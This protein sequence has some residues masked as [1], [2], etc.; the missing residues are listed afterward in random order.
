MTASTTTPPSE[1]NV[2]KALENPLEPTDTTSTTQAQTS[3]RLLDATRTAT[4]AVTTDKPLADKITD[5]ITNVENNPNVQSG[6]TKEQRTALEIQR[7]IREELA[8]KPAAERAALAQQLTKAL[9]KGWKVNVINDAKGEP[10]FQIGKV[11]GPTGGIREVARVQSKDVAVAGTNETD[12]QKGARLAERLKG[13]SGN[14]KFTEAWMK[15]ITGVANEYPVHQRGPNSPFAQFIKGFND[16]LKDEGVTGFD[17]AVKSDGKGLVL[18]RPD[19]KQPIGVD[20]GTPSDNAT[21][22][23]FVRETQV[24]PA[25]LLKTLNMEGVTPLDIARKFG[26]VLRAEGARNPADPKRRPEEHPEILRSKLQTALAGSGYEAKF[27]QTT[28]MFTLV[29]SD[30]NVV[31]RVDYNNVK[32]E[33]RTPPSPERTAGLLLEPLAAMNDVQRANYLSRASAWFNQPGRTEAEQ[34]AF[35]TALQTGFQ[36]YPEL[37]N[38]KI[39]GQ[40]LALDFSDNQ[41]LRA[42]LEKFKPIDPLDVPTRT[43]IPA[44]PVLPDALKQRV[45]VI[46]GIDD[47]LTQ[48]IKANIPPE[49]I[50]KGLN[51]TLAKLP[52]EKLFLTQDSATGNYVLRTGPTPTDQVIARFDAKNLQPTTDAAQMDRNSAARLLRPLVGLN[53]EQQKAYFAQ[54]VDTLRQAP[55]ETRRR[56][57]SAAVSEYLK[58][59]TTNPELK[60]LSITESNGNMTLAKDGRKLIDVPVKASTP[61]DSPVKPQPVNLEAILGKDQVAKLNTPEL[62]AAALKFF[63][64]AT[65]ANEKLKAAE[66]MANGGIK[67]LTVKDGEKSRTLT[68]QKSGP[69]MH[70][71]ANDNS[72]RNTI[73]L[74]GTKRG[75]D[76]VQQVGKNG[77][78]VGF[79]GD[80]WTKSVGKDSILGSNVATAADRPADAPRSEVN[81]VSDANR[82]LGLTPIV[83][84]DSAAFQTR[85]DQQVR[86]SDPTDLAPKSVVGDFSAY[87]KAS[88]GN[89]PQLDQAK[90]QKLAEAYSAALRAEALFNPPPAPVAG[91]DPAITAKKRA[92]YSAALVKRF[93]D[94]LPP[95]Y[96][97]LL[98][99]APDKTQ[100]GADIVAIQVATQGGFQSIAGEQLDLLGKPTVA[101]VD[102]IRRAKTDGERAQ[103]F[104]DM[105][106]REKLTNPVTS[107]NAA[108]LATRFQNILTAAQITDFK[109]DMTENGISLRKVATNEILS[110]INPANLPTKDAQGVVKENYL[111]LAG[112]LVEPLGAL[113][114]DEVKAYMQRIGASLKDV[115]A[116]QRAQLVE[117]I[118]AEMAKRQ[119]LSGFTLAEKPDGSGLVLTTNR[120]GET[121][122]EATYSA[123]TTG[124]RTAPVAATT[125]GQVDLKAIVGEAKLATLKP[126]QVAALQQL[127]KPGATQPEQL[128]AIETLAKSG[129][130]TL[131]IKDGDKD[132]TLSFA[133]QSA[134]KGKS[135]IGLFAT[136]DKG[137]SRIAIRGMN[138]GQ[139]N[140]VQQGK[141]SFYGTIWSRDIGNKSILTGG[142]AIPGTTQ[143]A[144]DQPVNVPT[145][146][147]GQKI[148]WNKPADNPVVITP[149]VTQPRV[150]Q[151]LTTAAPLNADAVVNSLV[152]AG[153]SGKNDGK[154][155]YQERIRMMLKDFNPE[156]MK[157]VK[158]KFENI[159]GTAFDTALTQKF[160]G[161]DLN[162]LKYLGEG[163][164]DRATRMIRAIQEREEWRIISGR[165][166]E[167]IEKDVRDT[168]ATM[169]AEQIAALEAKFAERVA[170]DPALAQ[171][172]GK[173]LTDIITGNSSFGQST[174]D[175]IA[176][177]KQGSD[178]ISDADRMKLV[179]LALNPKGDA[180]A[181]NL[182]QEATRYMPQDQRDRL[183][184]QMV[185]VAKKAANGN[186]KLQDQLTDYA[187]LGKPSTLTQIKGNLDWYGDNEL[188]IQNAL[189]NM[190]ETERKDLNEG[191]K[192]F[193]SPVANPTAE[194]QRQVELYKQYKAVFERAAKNTFG[195]T[196]NHELV[197][198]MDQ[199]LNGPNGSMVSR[200][201]AKE[202]GPTGAY[203]GWHNRDSNNL[204]DIMDKPWSKE[205]WKMANDTATRGQLKADILKALQANGADQNTIDKIMAQFDK[206]AA[207]ASPEAANLIT[208]SLADSINEKAGFFSSDSAGMMKAIF[209]MTDAQKQRLKDDPAYREQVLKSIRDRTS[210]A[211][212]IIDKVNPVSW[213]TNS[214]GMNLNWENTLG[215]LTMLEAS[216]AERA[217]NRFADNPSAKP[218]LLDKIAYHVTAGTSATEITADIEKFLQDPANKDAV[219]QF[220]ALVGKDAELKALIMSEGDRRFKSLTFGQND[221]S[222]VIQPLLKEGRVDIQARANMANGWFGYEDTKGFV[223]GLARAKKE[224]FDRIRA[225]P[226]ILDFLG[227]QEKQLAMKVTMQ[228]GELRPEDELRIAVLTGNL[229][230][231]EELSN[232]SPAEVM[233]QRQAYETAF[234]RLLTDDLRKMHK[235][236]ADRAA[237]NYDAPKS[238]MQMYDKLRDI[239]TSSADGAGLWM[240][241]KFDSGTEAQMQAQLDIVASR[242]T[243][244]GILKID[245]PPEERRKLM[246]TVMQAVDQYNKSE[247]AA[248][249]VVVQGVTIAAAI[250]IA[251]ASWGSGSAIS[252]SLIAWALGA[253]AA[254]A[255]AQPLLK[256]AILGN[257]YDLNSGEATKDSVLGFI[258]MAAA[259]FT[260]AHLARAMGVSS[261]FSKTGAAVLTN[262][263]K[264]VAT[265]TSTNI[266]TGKAVATLGETAVELSTRASAL[267]VKTSGEAVVGAADDV[268]RTSVQ[269]FVERSGAE[270]LDTA[271]A[272][273]VK[274]LS[275]ESLAKVTQEASGLLIAKANELA[276]LK[277][278]AAEIQ[279]ILAQEATNII[280][281]SM[282][283]VVQEA[284]EAT[285]Q[286]GVM[287]ASEQIFGHALNSGQATS[288]EQ[289]L[290][291]IAKEIPGISAEQ[292]ARM[293]QRL[294][295]EM[296]QLLTAASK[297]EIR[298]TLARITAE[299][300]ANPSKYQ[301]E[302]YKWA[303]QNP[304]KAMIALHTLTG[305]A[306][307]GLDGFARGL[308]EWDPSLSLQDNL[309]RIALSAGMGMGM[310]TLMGGGMSSVMNL[311]KIVRGQ[312]NFIRLAE[313]HIARA[314]DALPT[315][316]SKAVKI[317][318]P[319]TVIEGLKTR[320]LEIRGNGTTGGADIIV[321]SNVVASVDHNGGNPMLR[322]TSGDV[323]TSLDGG[324]TWVKA[325]GDTPLTNGTMIR[326]GQ[327]DNPV[328]FA[329]SGD[330][331]VLTGR[332]T[333]EALGIKFFGTKQPDVVPTLLESPTQIVH[334]GR[335]SFTLGDLGD[336]P[337]GIRDLNASISTEISG[338]RVS[339]VIRNNGTDPLNPMK[340]IVNG[341]EHTLTQGQEIKF[342]G[343]ARI[344]GAD[345]FDVNITAR[346]SGT[347]V[348]RIA[349]DA[350]PTNLAG[351]LADA[352]VI[353]R[354]GEVSA[355]LFKRSL[356]DAAVYSVQALDSLGQMRRAV[357]SVDAVLSVGGVVRGAFSRENWG[358]IARRLS[359]S[360]VVN[361]FKGRPE[362]NLAFRNEKS[363]TAAMVKAGFKETD[364]S[365]AEF[366]ALNK[367]ITAASKEE[368]PKLLADLAQL[369]RTFSK[370]MPDGSNLEV[371]VKGL[372]VTGD[373]VNGPNS[374]VWND[375]GMLIGFKGPNGFQDRVVNGVTS[376]LK[377][378]DKSNV[379]S[380]LLREFADATPGNPIDGFTLFAFGGDARTFHPPLST[381]DKAR[382]AE[383]LAQKAKDGRLPLIESSQLKRLQASEDLWANQIKQVANMEEAL[384]A[385][386]PNGKVF[387]VRNGDVPVDFADSNAMRQLFDSGNFREPF[388]SPSN[389]FRSA[390]KDMFWQ[391]DIGYVFQL[392]ESGVRV[393]Q[394]SNFTNNSA[395][396]RTLTANHAVTKTGAKH[397][398]RENETLDI[399]SIGNEIRSRFLRGRHMS[400]T[401]DANNQ[402]V[403]NGEFLVMRNGVFQKIR[404]TETL[405]QGDVIIVGRDMGNRL[406]K[407]EALI[408][409]K[410][411]GL[412]NIKS[413]LIYTGPGGPRVPL[414][415]YA[416]HLNRTL[417]RAAVQSFKSVLAANY[418]APFKWS[419]RNFQ[420]VS[421]YVKDYKNIQR[422]LNRGEF[423]SIDLKAK[424]KIEIVDGFIKITANPKEKI[425]VRVGD[426]VHT[427]EEEAMRFSAEQIRLGASLR[428]GEGREFKLSVPKSERIFADET[429]WSKMT[430]FRLK[431]HNPDDP[432]IEFAPVR[433]FKQNTENIGDSVQVQLIGHKRVA[434]KNLG[435][436]ENADNI[437]IR[438][439]NSPDAPFQQ[440]A[441][442][443]EYVPDGPVLVRIGDRTYQLEHVGRLGRRIENASLI[444]SMLPTISDK[445]GFRHIN[446]LMSRTVNLADSVV[447]VRLDKFARGSYTFEKRFARN[448]FTRLETSRVP[449]RIDLSDSVHVKLNGDKTATVISGGEPI[450]ALYVTRGSL[451][452]DHA[453]FTRNPLKRN[454]FVKVEN[455][456]LKKDQPFK[457]HEFGDTYTWNGKK[458]VRQQSKPDSLLKAPTESL[459]TIETV[460]P[461]GLGGTIDKVKAYQHAPLELKEG[462]VYTAGRS[463]LADL[464]SGHKSVSNE[465]SHLEFRL[466]V[467]DDGSPITKFEAK[468][469]TTAGNT[470]SY[471][472][473]ADGTF[474]E[475]SVGNNDVRVGGV[476]RIGKHDTFE[477][478]QN[479]DVVSLKPIRLSRETSNYLRFSDHPKVKELIEIPNEVGI[480][481]V[482]RRW[483]EKHA[484]KNGSENTTPFSNMAA[485]ISDDL[486][487]VATADGFT[488]TNLNPNK[489]LFI[490][491]KGSTDF[492]VAPSRAFVNPDDQFAVATSKEQ[493]GGIYT[494]F[495]KPPEVSRTVREIARAVVDYA[496]A[497]GDQGLKFS[498]RMWGTARTRYGEMNFDPRRTSI[499]AKNF[500]MVRGN[501]E[502]LRFKRGNLEIDNSASIRA[503]DAGFEIKPSLSPQNK[504]YLEVNGEFIPITEPIHITPGM[505]IRI[506]DVTSPDNV[507][508][509]NKLPGAWEL[510]S[511]VI[512]RTSGKTVG[513]AALAAAATLN[514]Y[515]TYTLPVYLA[516]KALSY[517]R[518]ARY[519]KWANNFAL[520]A[521]DTIQTFAKGVAHLE[522][523]A[524]IK[525]SEAG[526]TITASGKN[527]VSIR[528]ADGTLQRVDGEAKLNP[529]DSV[530]IG[531]RDY[532]L[533]KMAEVSDT[534]PPPS[535]LRNA[536]SSVRNSVV[537]RFKGM[538]LLDRAKALRLSDRVRATM[539]RFRSADDKFIPAK[540]SSL[541]DVSVF[542]R[543]GKHEV[544]EGK[545]LMFVEESGAFKVATAGEVPD[546]F[547]FKITSENDKLNLLANTEG[548]IVRREVG[549]PKVLTDMKVE[550]GKPFELQ[551]N[552]RLLIKNEAGV[553]VE[554]SVSGRLQAANGVEIPTNALESIRHD[555]GGF[556]GLRVSEFSVPPEGVVIG[557][558]RNSHIVLDGET[559]SKTAATIKHT[560]TQNVYELKAVMA[561]GTNV[562]QPQVFVSRA[563]LA[564]QDMDTI[565]LE[566][567]MKSATRLDTGV[568]N[569]ATNIRSGDLVIFGDSGKAVLVGENGNLYRFNIPAKALRERI[570]PEI[571][572]IQ[573]AITDMLDGKTPF[574]AKDLVR[575]LETH[576][577]DSP[578]AIKLSQFVKD[579]AGT[580]HID[581]LT[582][583]ETALNALKKLDDSAISAE[584]KASFEGALSAINTVR[585]AQTLLKAQEALNLQRA[586]I[587]KTLL[588]VTDPTN[589]NPVSNLL[590]ALKQL[591][592]NPKLLNDD[593]VAQLATALKS[594]RLSQ[595]NLQAV[596]D[597]LQKKELAFAATQ[598]TQFD[599]FLA[600]VTSA[601]ER[602]SQLE[603]PAG[604]PVNS[605]ITNTLTHLESIPPSSA[606][607]FD[608]FA[609]QA[610][611]HITN[612]PKILSETLTINGNTKT[613]AE[614][615]RDL[616]SRI[617]RDVSSPHA[618]KLDDALEQ[619]QNRI[620]AQVSDAE[621]AIE[622]WNA[623]ILIGYKTK[624]YATISNAKS[625]DDVRQIISYINSGN[626]NWVD[627]ALLSNLE[628]RL[629]E[630]L[631]SMSPA[632]TALLRSKIDLMRKSSNHPP[633]SS[634]FAALNRLEQRIAQNVEPENLPV[635]PS[636]PRN[637]QTDPSST[638]EARLRNAEVEQITPAERAVLETQDAFNNRLR[639]TDRT[640]EE[641]G[642][643]IL[644]I[645]ERNDAHLILDNYLESNLLNS[646]M[647]SGRPNQGL[648]ERL[649]LIDNISPQTNVTQR[650]SSFRAAL[651]KQ[652]TNS[653]RFVSSLSTFER[654]VKNVKELLNQIPDS[655]TLSDAI[656]ALRIIG[657]IR[658]VL[659][660]RR[661]LNDQLDILS[662][663]ID[664]RIGRH[665]AEFSEAP[666]LNTNTSS[667]H[668][669][670]DVNVSIYNARVVDLPS[671]VTIVSHYNSSR[672]SLDT[673]ISSR[674]FYSQIFADS[675]PQLTSNEAT[676][677]FSNTIL[678]R[679]DAAPLHSHI[680]RITN[681]IDDERSTLPVPQM[682]S[683]TLTFAA[684]DL[685]SGQGEIVIPI[686]RRGTAYT[687]IEGLTKQQ[688]AD[689]MV[690]GIIAFRNSHPDVKIKIATDGDEE[691][692][693]L[694]SEGLRNYQLKKK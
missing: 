363:M 126:D 437:Y 328:V 210:T 622:F 543:V 12:A 327:A 252:A 449:D 576:Q 223:E 466:G 355:N 180:T 175:A 48:Q 560:D 629:P 40:P 606:A 553:P 421:E 60:G 388:N 103:I 498:Q 643:V 435:V 565:S 519:R 474:K 132:R 140:Y 641:I 179:N 170:S 54:M 135:Y 467:G 524:K 345:G 1:E 538:R 485:N 521:D 368:R 151:P 2:P 113:K 583:L 43:D 31:G 383:L 448:S 527:D 112:R 130:R 397:I 178:K 362:A 566:T 468:A 649:R 554:Y 197:G 260:P 400:V 333:A 199:A 676:G 288:Y 226:A 349:S 243:E 637:P 640:Q 209:E 75:D 169:T 585:E 458:T 234:N 13:F 607:E 366:N 598:R 324:K 271:A 687:R 480:N 110:R 30:G 661:Q 173:S 535:R 218:D 436:G 593:I 212:W 373:S 191:R 133:V 546:N 627:A 118:K 609:A 52:G 420:R 302:M 463:R 570:A 639:T 612:N 628:S 90:A 138:D 657:S 393:T 229:Q 272:Q 655:L 459:P 611:L 646:I 689:D 488:A 99:F 317:E 677:N 370:T 293:A 238:V 62:Q 100:Q 631:S 367:L 287:K 581:D 149:D 86:F 85:M 454:E 325:A 582:K 433:Q 342:I 518:N 285:V 544:S 159:T 131:K 337:T 597:S 283:R 182:F 439:L 442:N 72:G 264:A 600:L 276:A 217:V 482:V 462:K 683:D 352:P 145:I 499:W 343:S 478:V 556:G 426:K 148:D 633:D 398:L 262:E 320:P 44:A 214:L 360:D 308:I 681:Y 512:S 232:K 418:S 313:T 685:P 37:Q 194:Q 579:N 69:Y 479:G 660:N 34:T 47:A 430:S 503:T 632:D 68:F 109:V 299:N 247:H 246:D 509:L 227:P 323:F 662:A 610:I 176:I 476:V 399:G 623:S 190:S 432:Y 240:V 65:P 666:L 522:G 78:P 638:T 24:T 684:R 242:M 105:M 186:E 213:L 134:G 294:T 21:L 319:N 573:T 425:Y 278:P 281:A 528:R 74:R 143:P 95:E 196:N 156:Q 428:I 486:R 338:T 125:D 354:P 434:I 50:L 311:G 659:N 526:F 616:L 645:S 164:D 589:A 371:F 423:D 396:S 490:K 77:R 617:Q 693:K 17:L 195:V 97:Q 266:F 305:T 654:T 230:R 441:R 184:D 248:A 231:L 188:G 174:K 177:L 648:I 124:D 605:T 64:A 525:A 129:L 206:R 464:P 584:A 269:A 431:E 417:S 172:K 237:L 615:L 92:D 26:D 330:S 534:P 545:P 346:R 491:R 594:D 228:N 531:S 688:I 58:S 220:N 572:K 233:L 94:G 361:A 245:I 533:T 158:Q 289:A 256:K 122:V 469:V 107:G 461:V 160:S 551:K 351:K 647:W 340:V 224:D 680:K 204:Q 483:S 530:V 402:V 315:D 694:I 475:M 127:L 559:V 163:L 613:G 487:V 473:Q 407:G 307:G 548:T 81:A 119:D 415:A 424:G 619:M 55:N 225:N 496:R 280:K 22:A 602:T 71:Y 552:D 98:K 344:K 387:Y 348:E 108:E 555:L 350:K 669:L 575:N 644:E 249:E 653:G 608:D 141:A 165:S 32:F 356:G 614:F 331:F 6:L 369:P 671:D 515:V 364:A 658:Q 359:N 27:D 460:L 253:G 591:E 620:Y 257:D 472:R 166:N 446:A 292:T 153:L 312:N 5:A 297:G 596:L 332:P 316:L 241:R 650:I 168:F 668:S 258:T 137:K 536:M 114:G 339:G 384:A 296:N 443:A 221:F 57:L 445:W 674:Y 563:A 121:P 452:K 106:R 9:P 692:A 389:P 382:M 656:E 84:N 523:K 192:L 377:S 115:P 222:A 539:E 562:E 577:I 682:I 279:A 586:T 580:L 590:L 142:K 144:A 76:Y 187:R 216:L 87:L 667:M 219:A 150:D 413:G 642:K 66:I 93:Q 215:S 14:D 56:M 116:P 7:V 484:V 53:E 477:V 207:A 38:L 259:P 268:I 36:K 547:A 625:F 500:E 506:G 568:N 35:R 41:K 200:F 517:A 120:Q 45:S 451:P 139:N 391:N 564:T 380:A 277:L 386:G 444:Y 529:N 403:A 456:Q 457:T 203:W 516:Y 664:R 412:Q 162:E 16:R 501:K 416:G 286:S 161:S 603:V 301:A 309:Q 358:E 298:T 29:K 89:P 39:N 505:R 510:P 189:R 51:D 365:S 254:G 334:P 20:F 357:L 295:M 675:R 300:I 102:M 291:I 504:I 470:Q 18:T 347:V 494:V 630:L 83:A 244:A 42:S 588:K 636:V 19:G 59:D 465:G 427:I 549:K 4:P 489:Q 542:A 678:T 136:D 270:L 25:D 595:E 265:S 154:P 601:K 167:I 493:I 440:L 686:M 497:K 70:V 15:A 80:R 282:E 520:N 376:A 185:E 394:R 537:E 571:L 558:S 3:E 96:A 624:N 261:I 673:E 374:F 511:S 111:Q 419:Y 450:K 665:L 679:S 67:S 587:E 329:Q 49:T 274:G 540:A 670:D 263:I 290:K 508:T 157:I 183:R 306:L 335:K 10:V 618:T 353:L 275:R 123:I 495:A 205:E 61:A 455:A 592:G 23:R 429:I 73:Y 250:A 82:M 104:S 181:F 404:G 255:V 235:P 392:T 378:F 117:A 672:D 409:D 385:A 28:N 691:I 569:G 395:L 284:A 532:K 152:D 406:V 410:D 211:G 46:R 304:L 91:E 146:F 303:M 273:G 502:A 79:Y 326:F 447:G 411:F 11:S 652:D 578:T 422:H 198:Y 634:S 381:A 401:R 202:D 322:V 550:V 567:A 341:I 63:D 492:E 513:K 651:E 318:T 101:F 541:D 663:S 314:A 321:P 414:T 336:I 574:N 626:E 561:A 128:K 88:L 635:E 408:V 471:I 8:K 453:D 379:D 372:K 171:Y 310:G 604:R 390:A 33:G 507:L 251:I 236:E 557:R 147:N 438:P 481:R 514:P 239:A 405:Q 621:L 193:E 208:R 201:L 599:A 375:K 267:L 690:A 155:A